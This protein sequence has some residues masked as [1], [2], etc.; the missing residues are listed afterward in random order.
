MDEKTSDE[1]LPDPEVA[2]GSDW[3]DGKQNG[4]RWASDAAEPSELQML[5]G[6]YPFNPS[7]VRSSRCRHI[8]K[9][10]G[11]TDGEGW[12]TLPSWL[13]REPKPTEEWFAGFVDGAL[14]VFEEGT[15]SSE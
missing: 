15:A 14:E 12:Q 9:M 3:A 10:L 13:E 4:R 11:R 8:A 6:L 7:D 1:E 5:D 2:A